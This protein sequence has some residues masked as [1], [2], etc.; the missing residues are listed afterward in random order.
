[1]DPTDILFLDA[2]Y[3]TFFDNV[4]LLLFFIFFGV[5]VLLGHS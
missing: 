2:A 1:M 5:A 3:I 4:F